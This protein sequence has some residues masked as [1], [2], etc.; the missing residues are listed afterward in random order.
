MADG[1]VDELGEG[2]AL[3]AGSAE[4]LGLA[5]ELGAADAVVG[6]GAGADACT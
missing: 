2:L 4:A 3:S 5:E 1:A 6:C